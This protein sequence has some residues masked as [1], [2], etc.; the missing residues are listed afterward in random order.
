MHT[1]QVSLKQYSIGQNSRLNVDSLA[2][3]LV[4]RHAQLSTQQV[5]LG[6]FGLIIFFYCL[7]LLRDVDA[8]IASTDL[9]VCL[10][11]YTQESND[12]DA[13]WKAGERP[14]IIGDW[15][16]GQGAQANTK[17][18]AVSHK[19]GPVLSYI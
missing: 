6:R 11:K 18:S 12:D 19:S 1:H 9:F 15:I 17:E 14:N 2:T 4:Q 7:D 10:P 5:A 16:T 8:F 3:S 13:D